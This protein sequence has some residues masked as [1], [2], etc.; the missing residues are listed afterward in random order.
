MTGGNGIG[1][2][3]TPDFSDLADM[4]ART[5][6]FDRP[7]PRR[8][9][10]TT[11]FTNAAPAPTAP[12]PAVDEEDMGL[13]EELYSENPSERDHG[14][15]DS[16]RIWTARNNEVEIEDNSIVPLHPFEL[17]SESSEASET[18]AETD[19]S[20]DSSNNNDAQHSDFVDMESAERQLHVSSED[21][22]DGHHC[23]NEDAVAAEDD[24]GGAGALPIGEELP[25]QE[26]DSESNYIDAVESNEDDDDDELESLAAL[27]SGNEDPLQENE[28]ETRSIAQDDASFHDTNDDSMTPVAIN[29]ND[30]EEHD[31]VEEEDQTTNTARLLR[32]FF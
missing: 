29:T 17:Q 28:D 3:T 2:D 20:S 31:A 10:V 1:G 13:F 18:E 11:P 5:E 8:N 15:D 24:A 23:D 27:F 6:V 25:P 4:V 30:T 14:P 16:W 26:D 7:R 21:T 19:D 22:N 12:T 9:N 32:S